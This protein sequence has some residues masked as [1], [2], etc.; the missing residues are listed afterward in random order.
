MIKECEQSVVKMYFVAYLVAPML[1][2]I[3]PKNWIHEIDKH[4]AKFVNN[5]IN[6]NQKHLCFYSEQPGA[7]IDRNDRFKEPNASFNPNFNLSQENVFP[8]E[9]C[10]VAHLICY[11]GIEY[12]FVFIINLY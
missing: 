1:H 2:T 7:M 3:V 10:Y 11:K 8:A 12:V 6:R 4:W 9:G 5:S